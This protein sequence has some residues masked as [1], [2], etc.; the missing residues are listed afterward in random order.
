MANTDRITVDGFVESGSNGFFKVRVNE[1]YVISA[2]I[3]GKIRQ[4]GVKILIGD[5]VTTE[6]SVYDPTKGRITFRHRTWLLFF[7]FSMSH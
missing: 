7:I 1:N 5:R 3:S 6:I 4:N 2:K